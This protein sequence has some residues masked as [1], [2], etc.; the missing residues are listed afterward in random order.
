MSLVI[1]ELT[2]IDIT[3]S[4]G[5][6]THSIVED[7]FKK[8]FIEFSKTNS[9]NCS[10][11]N[12]SNTLRVLCLKLTP[13]GFRLVVHT[14][15]YYEN[16]IFD[17]RVPLFDKKNVIIVKSYND[18]NNYLLD[19]IEKKDASI[20]VEINKILNDT[21]NRC[22]TFNTKQT[23]TNQVIDEQTQQTQQPSITYDPTKLYVKKTNTT[24]VQTNIKCVIPNQYREIIKLY[25]KDQCRINRQVNFRGVVSGII[26]RKNK[27]KSVLR[28]DRTN[29]TKMVLKIGTGRFFETEGD[30][31][32][33]WRVPRTE[34]NVKHIENAFIELNKWIEECK[35]EEERKR[36]EEEHKRKE[37]EEKIIQLIKT[38]S[39]VELK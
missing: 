11:I 5:L 6:I 13:P 26:L 2:F 37:E 35:V 7:S 16:L 14:G 1:E 22:R 36:K 21:Y 24:V 9:D 10:A 8:L 39:F 30:E 34:E 12:L 3:Y 31:N 27:N 29:K 18:L 17:F 28:H 20:Y 32:F 4:N 33:E 15:Q 25:G 19:R 23:K 38:E